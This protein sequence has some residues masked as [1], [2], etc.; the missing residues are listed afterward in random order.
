[1]AKPTKIRN[2]AALDRE[3]ARRAF[4]PNKDGQAKGDTS[5]SFVCDSSGEVVRLKNLL[6]SE[7]T[8][9]GRMSDAQS[10]D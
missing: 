10:G 3:L 7:D 4:D 1:M 9:D 8:R 2:Q 5:F 6:G